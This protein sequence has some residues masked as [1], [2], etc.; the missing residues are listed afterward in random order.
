M[1]YE[2]YLKRARRRVLEHAESPMY[3]E[4]MRG[5]MRHLAEPM[6]RSQQQMAKL[7]SDLPTQ[8]GFDF[9]LETQRQFTEAIGEAGARA[10]ESVMQTRREGRQHLE[11]IDLELARVREEQRRARMGFIQP[12]ATA[13][14]AGVGSIVPGVGTMLGASLGSMVGGIGQSM[15]TGQWETAARGVQEGILG[16]ATTIQDRQERAMT[17]EFADLYFKALDE[18]ILDKY[19][20]RE[21]NSM[22]LTTQDYQPVIDRLRRM[23]GEK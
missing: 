3:Y 6:R 4:M 22:L 10:T 12:I 7:A 2:S 5:T 21:L 20:M 13:V 16:L 11:Q 18:G 17:A 1:A 23:L 8:V 15:G 19:S 14:G 9:G